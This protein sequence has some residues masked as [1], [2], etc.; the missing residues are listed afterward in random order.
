MGGMTQAEAVSVMLEALGDRLT[1]EQRAFVEAVRGLA[2]VV[3][4]DPSNLS[5]WREYRLMLQALGEVTADGSGDTID[6][7][8][9]QFD[10][11]VLHPAD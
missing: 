8:L 11:E 5:A 6:Q 4:A 10:A 2:R 9:A 3:D 1:D 7:L